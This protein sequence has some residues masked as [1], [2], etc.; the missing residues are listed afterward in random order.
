MLPQLEV[1]DE[2]S[3]QLFKVVPIASQGKRRS[4]CSQKFRSLIG[5][6]SAKTTRYSSSYEKVEDDISDWI[7]V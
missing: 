2:L 1:M 6:K 4:L 7:L 3:Q 5:L